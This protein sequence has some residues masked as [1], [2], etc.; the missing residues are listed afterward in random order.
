MKKRSAFVTFKEVSA[1]YISKCRKSEIVGYGNT[2]LDSDDSLMHIPFGYQKKN[3][4]SS[5]VVGQPIFFNLKL[6]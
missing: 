3:S 2:C 5:S 4:W 1:L 6:S